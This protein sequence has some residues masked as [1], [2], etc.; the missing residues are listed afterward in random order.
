MIQITPA[1]QAAIKGAIEGA[2]QPVA[3]LRLMVQSGGC[4]GLKYGMSLELTEAPDDLVVEAEGLR[5]L[6]DPQSGTYLNG[7]TID[8]VTSLEGTGFVFDNPNAKGGCGCGKSFC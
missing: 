7:V 4:A 5:V 3:G 2:G 1:A 6:I 8:F